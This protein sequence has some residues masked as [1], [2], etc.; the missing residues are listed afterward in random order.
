MGLFHRGKC[1]TRTE[2]RKGGRGSTFLGLL[3]RHSSRL[4]L[5]SPEGPVSEMMG[6]SVT[7]LSWETVVFSRRSGQKGRCVRSKEEKM[8]FSGLWKEKS[9][10]PRSRQLCGATRCGTVQSSTEYRRIVT[11]TTTVS[12]P[13]RKSTRR[14]TGDLYAPRVAPTIRA[15]LIEPGP[16]R[17]S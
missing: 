8:V 5:L 13:R 17:S 15:R 3:A 16:V 9:T 14:Q 1:L 2:R 12:D 10:R 4:R 11:V 7:M 6:S